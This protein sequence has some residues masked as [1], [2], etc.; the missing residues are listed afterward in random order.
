[1]LSTKPLR[2]KVKFNDDLPFKNRAFCSISFKA[3][4]KDN[5]LTYEDFFS[6]R[7]ELLSFLL[8]YQIRIQQPLSFTNKR[9]DQLLIGF[10]CRPDIEDFIENF[11]YTF[12]HYDRQYQVTYNF[13]ELT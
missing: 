12:K 11:I 2:K 1:M 8:P 9:E 7:D 6:I 4:S 10:D 3:K 5:P 13:H